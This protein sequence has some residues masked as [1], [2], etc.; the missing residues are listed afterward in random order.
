[1]VI[2]PRYRGRCLERSKDG[3]IAVWGTVLAF[4]RPNHIVFSW[5]IGP[6]GA[7]TESEGASSRVDIRFSSDKADPDTCTILVVHRD[8][9]RHGDGWEKYRQDMAAKTG[10][11]ALIDAY[12]KALALTRLPHIA[13]FGGMKQ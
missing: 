6:N 3:S 12:V 9:F 1:M 11:P 2:E 4:E 10:W 13:M 7:P 5:Q 8:F